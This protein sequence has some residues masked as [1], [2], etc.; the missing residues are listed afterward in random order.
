MWAKTEK[1]KTIS[2]ISEA[3]FPARHPRKSS[4]HAYRGACAAADGAFC[5]KNRKIVPY[6]GAYPNTKNGFAGGPEK[7]PGLSSGNG[8]LASSYAVASIFLLLHKPSRFHVALGLFNNR[9]QESSEY[10]KN[11]SDILGSRLVCHMFVFVRCQARETLEM[12]LS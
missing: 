7:F 5:S 6:Y 12:K 2:G 8:P 11:I 4:Q 3:I 1:H 9:S 10:G